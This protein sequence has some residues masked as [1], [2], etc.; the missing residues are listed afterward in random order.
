[1]QITSAPFESSALALTHSALAQWGT[2]FL[3]ACILLPGRRSCLYAKL[4]MQSADSYKNKAVHKAANIAQL[5]LYLTL[6]K[7]RAKCR[8]K[9]RNLSGLADGHPGFDCVVTELLISHT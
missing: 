2:A 7:Y 3:L 9:C 6:Y 1:M 5:S 8:A 4:R